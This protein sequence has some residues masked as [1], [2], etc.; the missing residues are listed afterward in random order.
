M[1]FGLFYDVT[2]DEAMQRD[3]SSDSINKTDSI[4]DRHLLLF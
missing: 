2:K 3:R 4:A 1:E